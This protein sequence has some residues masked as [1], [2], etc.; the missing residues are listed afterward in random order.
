MKPYLTAARRVNAGLTILLCA[1]LASVYQ[2]YNVNRRADRIAT[3]VRDLSDA[4]KTLAH[5]VEALN[6]RVLD[7]VDEGGACKT[8]NDQATAA[9]VAN[10]VDT[11]HTDLD[12]TLAQLEN[13][14]EKLR[15]DQA[16]ARTPLPPVVV[17]IPTP[18]PA[19]PPQVVT[20]P[21]APALC[22][23]L[24]PLTVGCNP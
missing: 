17:T 19:P 5:T 4:T 1:A 11:L 10:I 18:R 3:S 21:Q 24:G 22:L 16:I 23:P 13:D 2:G 15:R 12:A 8:A 20:I 6:G 7:C 14:L 9:A